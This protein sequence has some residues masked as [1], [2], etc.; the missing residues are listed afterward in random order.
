YRLTPDNERT[1]TQFEAPEVSLPLRTNN[2]GLRRDSRTEVEKPVGRARVLVL[3]DS[4]TEGLV[5]N[6]DTYTA[7][8]EES[9]VTEG[10]AAEVLN[11][12]ASGYS[13]LLKYLWLRERGA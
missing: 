5:R 12:G 8:L 6:R 2:L 1:L 3:G 11:A 10:A 7:V 13:P 9:L 4:Q